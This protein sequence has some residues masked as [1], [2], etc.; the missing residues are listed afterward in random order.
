MLDR[1]ARGLKPIEGPLE[2]GKKRD[3]EDE[4][5]MAAIDEITDET[6]D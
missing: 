4:D 6:S 2:V 1:M 5:L 3:S